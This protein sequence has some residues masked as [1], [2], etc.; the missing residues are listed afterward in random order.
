[1]GLTYH[2]INFI[3]VLLTG[4]SFCCIFIIWFEPLERNETRF[5]RHL[6]LLGCILL[7]LLLYTISFSIVKSGVNNYGATYART[8]SST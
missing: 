2:L 5:R 4:A 3:I 8:T 6:K 7:T 1:M